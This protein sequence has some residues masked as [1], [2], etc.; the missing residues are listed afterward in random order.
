MNGV[1][2]ALYALMALSLHRLFAGPSL[3]DRLVATH[4]VSAVIVLLLCVHA[5]EAG[6]AFYL[7]VA[8]IYALLSFAETIAFARLRPPARRR[9]AP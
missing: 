5:V 4:L 1:I 6:R 2:L 9:P 3:Y 7:D 8:M